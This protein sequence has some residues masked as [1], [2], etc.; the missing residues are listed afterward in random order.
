MNELLK[1]ATFKS[2]V[3]GDTAKFNID[4]ETVSIRFLAVDTPESV[5]P[6]KAEEKFGK[7]ASEF[8]CNSL[9]NA[10]NIIIETDPNAQEKDKYDR[11]L[12]WIWV[13]NELLQKKLI[14]NGYAQVAYVYKD[15]K[16]VKNL[17][18]IQSDAKKN[19][20]NVW[21]NKKYEEGYCKTIDIEGVSKEITL[22]TS[23][24]N[25]TPKENTYNMTWVYTGIAIILIIILL[26]NKKTRQKTLNK[27]LKKIK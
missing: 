19:K 8:T 20:L 13:D 2:C 27:M 6:K 24:V 1:T 16:Y 11:S 23:S 10:E 4:D 22:D 3:D 18:A 15:Y 21:S 17:C 12:A 9:K 5:H 25:E 7:E 14:E 26:I